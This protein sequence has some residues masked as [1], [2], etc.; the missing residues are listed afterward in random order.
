MKH[1]KKQLALFLAVCMLLSMLPLQV[2][3]AEDASGYTAGM[4]SQLE[5]DPLREAA[6]EEDEPVEEGNGPTDEVVDPTDEG[7]EPTD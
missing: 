4:A 5:E 1:L 7:N 6:S 3:A 2:F